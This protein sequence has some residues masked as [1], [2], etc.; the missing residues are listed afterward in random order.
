MLHVKLPPGEF[1]ADAGSNE[2]EAVTSV[3]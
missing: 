1:V 3:L 2:N